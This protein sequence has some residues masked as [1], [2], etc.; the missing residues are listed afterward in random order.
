LRR[1]WTS[2]GYGDSRRKSPPPP[3]TT[4]ALRRSPIRRRSPT[5]FITRDR[6]TGQYVSNFRRP[7]R[8]TTT[9]GLA[10]NVYPRSPIEGQTPLVLRPVPDGASDVHIACHN[11]MVNML[12]LLRIST[13]RVESTRRA[14]DASRR[15][16]ADTSVLQRAHNEVYTEI[17]SIT[18]NLIAFEREIHNYEERFLVGR[19]PTDVDT[20]NR[21]QVLQ[22]QVHITVD[23]LMKSLDRSMEFVFHV[24]VSTHESRRRTAAQLEEHGIPP[25]PVILERLSSGSAGVNDGTAALWNAHADNLSLL[26]QLRVPSPPMRAT[27]I[28][29]SAGG[30]GDRTRSATPDHDATIWDTMAMTMAPDA[31]LPSTDSSFTS[32]AA[33]ASFSAP[34]T[35][36]S[37]MTSSNSAN[38]SRTSLTAPDD[39]ACDSDDNSDLPVEIGV[40]RRVISSEDVISPSSL[41]QDSAIDFVRSYNRFAAPPTRPHVMTSRTASAP[42]IARPQGRQ[43]TITAPTSSAS[44]HTPPTYIISIP[45]STSPMPMGHDEFPPAGS[46]TAL[47]TLTQPLNENRGPNVVSESQSEIQPRRRAVYRRYSRTGRSRRQNTD[48]SPTSMDPLAHPELEY[49]RSILQEMANSR[50]IPEE[51][52]SLHISGISISY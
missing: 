50:D 34:A 16:F 38:S 5:R 47:P 15:P 48:A 11:M 41:Y 1:V 21:F 17:D 28:V 44:P 26:S 9:P 29:S 22:D 8:P 25:T 4:P 23:H 14:L 40:V 45:R 46:T 33:A 39:S 20:M 51:W 6:E 49:M 13:H 42:T 32:A 24:D 30:L 43:Y 31:Q 10:T 12:E 3:V 37:S 36:S 27:N 7:L 2:I 52:V 19:N 18:R 35:D